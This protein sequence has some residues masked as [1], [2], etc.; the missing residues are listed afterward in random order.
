MARVIMN[1]QSGCHKHVT[2][3][4]DPGII[5]VDRQAKPGGAKQEWRRLTWTAGIALTTMLALAACQP[6]VTDED[7]GQLDV[8]KP[9]HVERVRV[10]YDAAFEP[11]KA[12]LPHDQALRL[13]AFLDQAAIRPNDSVFIA[14]PPGDPMAAARTKRIAALL[15]QRSVSVLPIAAP[16]SGVASDHLL[17]L[18][19]RYVATPPAC[20]DW[21]GSPMT[22]HDNEPGSN[23]GCA[24]ATDL[25]EMV[26]NPRDLETGRALGPYDAE[27]GLG[28]IERYR[29]GA[30]KPLLGAGGQTGG[31]PSGSSSSS[32]PGAAAA[33]GGAS[34][35]ASGGASPTPGQ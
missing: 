16:P 22:G 23:F 1:S 17:I 28:A 34:G 13:E 33:M 8:A 10:Q 24:D 12:E 27:P 31:G 21:S 2:A 14:S 3:G 15:A 11:G 7:M 5:H 18:V 6:L 30:V 26:A 25:A 19:D 4:L 29:A 32:L 20:P 35:A 9:I